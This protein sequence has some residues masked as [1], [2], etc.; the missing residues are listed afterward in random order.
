MYIIDSIQSI[1]KNAK[2]ITMGDFNDDPTNESIKKILGAKDSRNN[3]KKLRL[4]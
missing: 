4:I 3:L 2:I 1:N